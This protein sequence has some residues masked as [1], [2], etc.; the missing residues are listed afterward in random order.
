MLGWFLSDQWFERRVGFIWGSRF[1]RSDN[2]GRVRKRVVI[3]AIIIELGR[4]VI[5]IFVM[6]SVPRCH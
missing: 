4:V 6:I 1:P 2:E 5:R 3:E